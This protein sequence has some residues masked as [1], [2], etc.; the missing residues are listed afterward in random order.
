[1]ER[2]TP[3]MPPVEHFALNFGRGPATIH[4]VEEC[5]LKDSPHVYAVYL[6]GNRVVDGPCNSLADARAIA[7]RA[8]LGELKQNIND[9]EVTMKA[10]NETLNTLKLT[11]EASMDDA[12]PFYLAQFLV[13]TL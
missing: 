11:I 2:T 5:P 13:R 3:P 7:M 1:M 4:I 9:A 12:D 8:A 6:N 10:A